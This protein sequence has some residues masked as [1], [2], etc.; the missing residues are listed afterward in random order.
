MA[1]TATHDAVLLPSSEDAAP[2]SPPEAKPSDAGRSPLSGA[3]SVGIFG[4]IGFAAL[5][6]VVLLL[7]LAFMVLTA[8][9]PGVLI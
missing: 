5:L 1:A 8:V 7:I 4:L 9:A 6:M 2:D 3:V